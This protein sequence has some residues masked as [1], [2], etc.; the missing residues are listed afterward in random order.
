MLTISKV[1]L[2]NRILKFIESS[3]GCKST[4]LLYQLR[5]SDISK[6]L[7]KYDLNINIILNE[8]V[9]EQKI[10]KIQ[11]TIPKTICGSKSF[12]LPIN[13]DIKIDNYDIITN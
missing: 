4:D 13:T 11:Y 12:L 10:I 9:N 6:A 2:K 7:L 3:Q 8:L 1:E 5:D